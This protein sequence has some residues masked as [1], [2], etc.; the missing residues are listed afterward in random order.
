[1][2][3]NINSILW[4]IATSLIIMSSF[5]FTINLNL[6]QFQFKEMFKNIFKKGNKEK[7][8]TPIQSLMMS[9]AARIGVGSIAGVALAIHIGGIGSIFWMWITAFL[10]ATNSFSETVLGIIY[11]EK[12]GDNLYKGG[13]S[14]YLK[15]GLNKPK[16]G[17]IYALLILFSYVGGY[18]SIQA[19]T[20]TKS[21]RVLIDIPPFIV[22][23]LICFA[24]SLVI[25]GGVKKIASF[26][27]KLV[28]IMTIFYL[29]IAVFVIVTHISLIPSIFINIIKNA[30]SF[31][32]ASGG[33]L[34]TIIVGAQRGI[35]SN[36]A[37]IG[38][39]SITSSASNPDTPASLGYIQMIGIYVTTLLICTATAIIILTSNYHELVLTDVNGIEIT[40]YAFKYHLGNFGNIAIFIA[41][42]LFSF[43]TILTGYYDGESSL[44]YFFKEI[45]NWQ[46]NI[47]KIISLVVLFMGCIISSQTLWNMVDILTAIL[48]IIN[49]YALLGLRK[50]IISEYH[51]YKSKKCGKI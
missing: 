2:L 37:G 41:I 32:A 25:Y 51:Y 13:P 30:F 31:K 49:I 14:Y 26:T 29:S 5:Y 11:Q 6:I 20:I 36:E 9:L 1:M 17:S 35:F 39:C 23:I 24:T 48:A 42:L 43:S 45:K 8:I 27:E 40:Q 4:A 16:L 38:T 21:A 3:E 28:P 33:I 12:D 47:L 34:G 44:K 18:V 46:V 22:G 10:A 19:N 7:G 15:K 50:E